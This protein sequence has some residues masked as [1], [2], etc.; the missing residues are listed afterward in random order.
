VI[1]RDPPVGVIRWLSK[2]LRLALALAADSR[3]PTGGT[4]GF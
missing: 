4:F 3:A 1:L 2:E